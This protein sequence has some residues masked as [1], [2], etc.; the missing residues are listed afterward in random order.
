MQYTQIYDYLKDNLTEYRYKHTLGVAETAKSLAENY[1]ANPDKAYLAGLLHDCAKEL[2][3]E[4]ML[5]LAEKHNVEIDD[6]AKSSTALLHGICGAYLARDLY[7][8]DDEI[9]DAIR[10]HTTG[11]ADMSLLEKIIY[12]ADYIE[13]NRNFDGVKEV[14]ELAF[15]DIDE[16]IIIS[17]GRVIVHTVNKGGVVHPNTVEARNY[18][19]LDNR[20]DAVNEKNCR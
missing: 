9:F 12:I 5:K 18:L 15:S 20:R 6:L 11:K 1:G 7:N 2:S 8:I 17:C 3:L 16:A 14:R 4:Q 10:F 19:L 13:P